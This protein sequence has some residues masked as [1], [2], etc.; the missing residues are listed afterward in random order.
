METL[1]KGEYKEIHNGH[2]SALTYYDKSKVN[3]L[4]NLMVADKLVS[5]DK[6]NKS[7]P[8]ALYYYRL[9]LG[10]V[11][12]HDRQVHQYW[13]HHK[14]LKWHSAFLMAILKIAISNTWIIYNYLHKSDKPFSIKDITSTIIKHLSGITTLRGDDNKPSELLKRDQINHWPESAK[15]NNC[16]QCL[17]VGK[18]SSTSYQ[19]TKCNVHLH[20]LCFQKYHCQ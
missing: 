18:K 4:T 11:D 2:F 13:P 17:K 14:N 12:Q 8:I 5:S 6:S 9:W 20:P 16:V 7:I 3:L 1:K 19:C 10:S 15:K